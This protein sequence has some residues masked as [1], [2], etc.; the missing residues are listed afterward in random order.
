MEEEQQNQNK[1]ISV[2]SFFAFKFLRKLDSSGYLFPLYLLII[3]RRFIFS[4]QFFYNLDCNIVYI[5]IRYIFSVKVFQNIFQGS[6][7]LRTLFII[8]L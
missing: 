2:K 3:H 6:Y 7:F 4:F 1:T 8:Y 5:F